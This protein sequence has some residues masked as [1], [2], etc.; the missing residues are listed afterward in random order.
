VTTN[1]S[2]ALARRAARALVLTPAVLVLTGTAPA[3]AT[4]PEQW[5][6]E[7]VSPLHALLVLAVIP[8][9]LFVLITVLAYVP[10]MARGEKYTPGLAW[11]SEPE[12]FGG[13]SRG[14]DATED[15]GRPAVEAGRD[16]RGGAS[17]HW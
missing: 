14:L 11:R 8:I 10:S 5:A 4:A 1:H 15:A 12:W 6:E 16:D 13:P 2:D 17:A 9:G 3:L 7:S